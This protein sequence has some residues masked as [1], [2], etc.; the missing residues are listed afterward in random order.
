MP[1]ELQT[2]NLPQSFPAVWRRVMTEPRRFFEDMPVTGG[3]QNP[4]VFLLICLA[5]SAVAFLLIG[6]RPFAVR[7]LVVG[8]VRAFVGALV[9]MIVA[10]QVFHG[11]GDYEGTFRAVAYG[12]APAA[13]LW[14]PFVR[15][16]VVLYA[17]FLLVVGLERVHTFDAT[18]A[19]LTILLSAVVL[20]AVMWVLGWGHM[21]MPPPDAA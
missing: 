11:S 9:L 16:L 10:Q 13:L 14:L 5:I 18:K 8:V 12:S 15:P 7:I 1:E 6:P 4:F 19:V 20:L 2:D 17:L 3:L 21:W